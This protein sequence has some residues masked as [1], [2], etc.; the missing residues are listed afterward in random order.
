MPVLLKQVEN[1][2]SLPDSKTWTIKQSIHQSGLD[3]ILSESPYSIS[4]KICKR[5]L[6]DRSQEM[7][8]PQTLE[9][10]TATFPLPPPPNHNDS[11]FEEL[12]QEITRLT[13]T[14]DEKDNKIKAITETKKKT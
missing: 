8:P 11:K 12:E 7:S 13:N 14:I 6:Q 5:F 2:R 10:N 1:E 3:F 9:S 4:V